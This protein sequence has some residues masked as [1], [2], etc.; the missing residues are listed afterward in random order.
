MK[1]QDIFTALLKDAKVTRYAENK[2]TLKFDS[3][4]KSNHFEKY[5]KVRFED[6]ASKLFG[7][8]IKVEVEGTHNKQF[9]RFNQNHANAESHR[10]RTNLFC[11]QAD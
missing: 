7:E 8:E 2:L 5:Y 6:S 10:Q 4:Y 9:G 3:E 11:E 1:D